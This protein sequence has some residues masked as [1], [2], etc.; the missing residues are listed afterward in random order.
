MVERTDILNGRKMIQ[1][2]S[3]NANILNCEIK[4]LEELSRAFLTISEN[5]ESKGETAEA[6]RQQMLDYKNLIDSAISA[7]NYDF[8]DNYT[9]KCSFENYYFYGEEIIQNQLNALAEKAS[10]EA[11]RDYHYRKWQD[12]FDS[13]LGFF[14]E[15]YHYNAYNFYCN[16][17]D[18]DQREYEYWNRIESI[19]DIIKSN[20]S[21]LFLDSIALRKAIISG[22]EEIQDNFV[23][24]N[25]TVDLNANWRLELVDAFSVLIAKKFGIRLFGNYELDADL[26]YQEIDRVDEMSDSE[27]RAFVKTLK[28]LGFDID[29]NC[30]R[31]KLKDEVLAYLDKKMTENL[32]D[33][34]GNVIST[35]FEQLSYEERKLYVL[36]YESQNPTDAGKMD[37][38]TKDMPTGTVLNVWNNEHS[39]DEDNINIRFM[40]YTAPEPEKSLFLKYASD[41]EV[42]WDCGCNPYWGY[43]SDKGKM[44]IH[45][46]LTGYIDEDGNNQPGG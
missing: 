16:C 4:E 46:D 45:V 43:D 17:V 18:N 42:E 33:E 7:D 14:T 2:S 20:T 22:L 32:T 21:Y 39:Y 41:V 10:D 8:S 31:E 23:D 6:F 27:Y 44:V 26:V 9:A 3:L 36:I 12:S 37:D 38:F 35:P 13:I 19:F 34:Y 1:Q 29:E 40:V 28:S 30:P 5:D 15:S 25:Y 24:G 11:R